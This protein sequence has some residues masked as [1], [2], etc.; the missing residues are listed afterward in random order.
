[1][2][3]FL[4]ILLALA[5]LVTGTDLFAGSIDYVSNQSAEYIRSL[6][7]N[8]STD[9]ADIA[10]YNPAGLVLLQDGIYFNLSNQFVLKSFTMETAAGDEYEST[11]PTLLL[12]NFFAVWSQGDWAAYAAVNV[13]AGGGTLIY[14]DGTPLSNGYGLDSAELSSMYLGLTIGGSYAINDMISVAL[15]LRVVRSIKTIEVSS[16]ANDL[17]VDLEAMGYTGIIGL[18]IAPM[19]GLNIGIR[20][21]TAT[22]LEYDITAGGTLAALSGLLGYPDGE[23]YK[24]DLP[25]I[26][27]IGFTY[28]IMPGLTVGGDFQY[29]FLKSMTIEDGNGEDANEYDDGWETGLFVAYTVM[30]GLLTSIGYKYTKMGSNEDTVG[31]FSIELDSQS[32]GLGARYDVMPNLALEIGFAYV[33]YKDLEDAAGTTYSRTAMTLAI[34]AQYRM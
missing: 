24:K 13:V 33:F 10:A 11:E 26:A 23:K 21:E 2:K 6:N 5:L 18:N 9:S 29:Y 7:R 28:V 4:V 14:E 1:M 3:K 17:T 22:A 30:P 19:T 27:A 25:A 20:Y 34:G 12:P 31:D 8:G 15:G 32:I 16:A